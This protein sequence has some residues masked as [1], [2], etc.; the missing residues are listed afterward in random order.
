MQNP[1]FKPGEIVH[2]TSQKVKLSTPTFEWQEK[3]DPKKNA[4][5]TLS[6]MEK[7]ITEKKEWLQKEEASRLEE[8]EKKRIEI[9][10]GTE[11]ECRYKR[12]AC[13]QK[14]AAEE[15]ALQ[16]KCRKLLEEARQEAEEI[17]E[18]AKG[19]EEK[20]KTEAR[21]EGFAEGKDRGAEE[22]LKEFEKLNERFRV[23]IGRVLEKRK[24][25]INGS[26]VQLIE[27]VLL[28][29][30]RVVKVLSETQKNIIIQNISEAVRK[31]KQKGD[32]VIRVNLSD[33]EMASKHKYEFIRLVESVQG[34]EFLEDP[35]IERGGCVV[36][37]DFGEIDARISSQLSEIEQKI[38]EMI[39]RSGVQAV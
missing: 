31:L 36:E 29:V 2:L 39:P 35:L 37:T 34:I 6:E 1:I 14:I 20:L 7:T 26:E 5:L 25:V 38:K 13:A 33:I 10:E 16:E 9:L 32:I 11:Q 12:E 23:I 24:E 8:L 19:E 21:A 30:K 18:K 22:G 28:M 4:E 15:E 3:E 17:L 27:L